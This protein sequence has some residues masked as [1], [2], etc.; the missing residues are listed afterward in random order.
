MNEVATKY[1]LFGLGALLSLN[2]AQAGLFQTV[3]IY[4]TML[5]FIGIIA[6]ALL[7]QV[8]DHK[9]RSIMYIFYYSFL[10]IWYLGIII[11][12]FITFN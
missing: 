2:Y 4:V 6:S 9:K 1:Y 10:F 12:F 8:I 11:D 3:M 5:G 7:P